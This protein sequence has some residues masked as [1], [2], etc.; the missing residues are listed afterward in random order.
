MELYIYPTSRKKLFTNREHLRSEIKIS[1]NQLEK[2]RGK[3]LCFCGLRK[4]GKTELLKY[5]L[6][7][8]ILSSQVIYLDLEEAG[9]TPEAFVKYYYCMIGYWI[10]TKGQ[11]SPQKYHNVNFVI[12][13]AI[14]NNETTIANT[15]LALNTE[16]E[17]INIDQR[18]ILELVFG[19]LESVAI[20]KNSFAV[21]F[22][23]EFQEILQLNN[24]RQI[25]N[26]IA[27]FRANLQKQNRT[28]YI[29]AGSATR[30]LE[31][32]ICDASSP[33][34]GH[35]TLRHIEP[36]T[37]EDTFE[38]T[39]KLIKRLTDMEKYMVYKLTGGHPYYIYSLCNRLEIMLERY[40]RMEEMVKKAFVFEVCSKEGD[41]NMHCNYVFSISL[42]QARGY[43][44]LRTILLELAQEDGLKLSQISRKVQRGTGEILTYLNNLIN[45]DLL[46]KRDKKYY[47]KDQVLRYWLLK[48][49]LGIEPMLP[50]DR[51][52]NELVSELEEKYQRIAT[53]LGVA[54]QSEIQDVEEINITLE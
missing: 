9:L 26:I 2:G 22:I 31:N 6:S 1:L 21:V 33:I 47:F 48:F 39:D 23:D 36:F 16:L 52:M 28:R 4:I 20:E 42:A 7:E 41:I 25:K 10:L 51:I 24:F 46:I 38:F 53:E 44:S 15:G 13:E 54:K 5:S 49:R 45:V 34:F 37:K 30:I 29:I 3:H 8:Q 27:L 40:G 32:I 35:F 12:Q 18:Y 50:T 14:K 19:L 11:V 43:A 17:K